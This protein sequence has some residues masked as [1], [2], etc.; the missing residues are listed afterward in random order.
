MS[1]EFDP[2]TQVVYYKEAGYCGS[3]VHYYCSIEVVNRYGG[4]ENVPRG[5]G[6]MFIV[7]MPCEH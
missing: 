1:K 2:E 3:T 4:I 7:G 6:G 5:T